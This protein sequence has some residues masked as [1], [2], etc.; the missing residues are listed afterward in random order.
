VSDGLELRDIVDIINRHHK[1][2]LCSLALAIGIALLVN[3]II[4]PKYEANVTMRIKVSK[5]ETDNNNNNVTLSDELMRQ[6]IFTYAEIIKSR[7]VVEAVIDKEYGDQEIQPTYEELAQDMDIQL[8]KNT[9][10]LNL[11]VQMDSAEQAQRIANATMVAFMQRLTEI[12]RLEGKETRVFLGERL[13]EAKRAL[14]KAEQELVEYKETK[15]ALAV[16]TQTNLYLERQNALI[17]QAGDNQLALAGGQAKLTTVDNQLFNQSPGIVADNLL[18]Q[19]YKNKLA[20]QEIELVG[21]SKN[22]TLNHPRVI[23][24]QAS[25]DETKTQLKEEVAKVVR[26]ESGS[27][28]GVNQIL[29]QSKAQT[30]GDL[31][32]ARVQKSVLD[33]LGEDGKKELNALPAKEQGL[34]RL[35][36]DYSM[37]ESE[38]TTLSKRYEDARISEATQPTNVQIIDM[39]ALPQKPVKPR[40]LI[41]LA[42]A[43][44]IGLFVSLSAAFM[45]EYFHKTIDTTEDI[46]RYLGATVIGSIPKYTGRG[47]QGSSFW[48]KIKKIF[49]FKLSKGG[50]HRRKSS[51]G[52]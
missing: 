29:L 22:L 46:R 19:Q 36:L 48:Q 47:R 45:A 50:K 33:R 52:N 12:V 26:Q 20:D 21:L 23:T 42:V 17:R 37:R 38:Y 24:L 30:E 10:I 3:N 51:H 49:S 41:N 16:T 40:R 4:P 8:V 32:V 34:A 25:I 6:Q 7:T 27:T 35:L 5:Q 28:N 31:A 9:T 39:A 2:I 15:G 1:L 44:A 18:I 11:A 43:L 14:D 13:A